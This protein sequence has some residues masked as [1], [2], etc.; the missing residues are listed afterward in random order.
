MR[1]NGDEE[2]TTIGPNTKI[3]I[4]TAGTVFCSLFGALIWGRSQVEDLKGE[5][6]KIWTTEDQ[7]N[8]SDQ[9]RR[10]NPGVSV[11]DPLDIR[12]MRRVEAHHTN[13][14]PLAAISRP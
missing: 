9:L 8:F 13:K 3:S 10:S 12:R 2:K 11:P 4:L 1:H 6:K 14:G 7:Q 5:V